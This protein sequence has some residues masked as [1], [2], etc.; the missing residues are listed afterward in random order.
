MRILIVEDEE[1]AARGLERMIREI[2][3]K[4]I[5]SLHKEK[6]LL[7]SQCYILENPIDLLFLDLNLDGDIGFELLKETSAESFLTIIVSGNISEAIRAFEYGVLDFVPKPISKERIVFALDKYLNNR[8]TPKTKYLG[9]KT[10]T[11]LSL[12]STK[13][14]LYI[15]SFNKKVKLIKKNGDILIHNKSLEAIQRILPNHFKRIHRTFVINSK[16]LDK[17]QTSPG[18]DYKAILKDGTTL[19]MSRSFYRAFK[20]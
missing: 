19:K 15:Q 7:A 9:I 16:Q 18:G 3:G 8:N 20:K 5:T 2:L 14:V 6:S 17:I 10:E 11:G 1:V 4:K 13:D 12:V